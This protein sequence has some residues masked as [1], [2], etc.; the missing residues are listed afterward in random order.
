VL[1]S[2]FCTLKPASSPSANKLVSAPRLFVYLKLTKSL[3]LANRHSPK[4]TSKTYKTPLPNKKSIENEKH[5][6]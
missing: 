2:K 6:N 5:T 3:T 1:G 4:T